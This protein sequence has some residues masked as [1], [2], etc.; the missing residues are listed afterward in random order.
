MCWVTQGTDYIQKCGASFMKKLV[1]VLV[2]FLAACSS[3]YKTYSFDA[4]PQPLSSSEAAYVMMARDNFAASTG[5]P[6]LGNTGAG[7]GRMVSQIVHSVV[8]TRFSKSE[9]AETPESLNQALAK[10]R[11]MGAAYVFEPSIRNWEDWVTVWAGLPD[12]ITIR[13]TVWDAATGK[14]LASSV[15]RASSFEVDQPQDLVPQIMKSF[16]NRVL[17]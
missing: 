14:K 13:I 4:P 11:A 9:L 10:A 8:L 7:S 17:P 15:E 2:L 12:R 5:H 1:I 6:E 3:E 16:L